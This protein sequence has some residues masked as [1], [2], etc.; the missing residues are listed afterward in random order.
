MWDV[1]DLDDK[2][3]DKLLAAAWDAPTGDPLKKVR[4]GMLRLA[5]FV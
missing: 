5:E 3:S 1:V 2:E 4:D